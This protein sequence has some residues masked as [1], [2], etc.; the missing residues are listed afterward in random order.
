MLA[1]IVGDERDRATKEMRRAEGPRWVAPRAPGDEQG[2]GGG[3]VGYS[4]ELLRGALIYA[5]TGVPVL[6]C[7]AQG[8][9]PL[10]SEGFFEATTDEARIRRWWGR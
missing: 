2:P 8:K 3:I 7:E 10:T 1:C 6:P 4:H 9:R 5:G